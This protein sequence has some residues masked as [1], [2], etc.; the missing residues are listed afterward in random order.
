M[1]ASLINIIGSFGVSALLLSTPLPNF[2]GF[3][4]AHK[5]EVIAFYVLLF[6]AIVLFFYFFEQNLAPATKWLLIILFA[7]RNVAS[8]GEV[9]LIKKHKEVL[10]FVVNAGYALLFFASHYYFT[11][12]PFQMHLLLV[13]LITLTLLKAAVLLLWPV[14][15]PAEST[16]NKKGLISNWFFFGLNDLFG[17]TAKWIDKLFLVYL[18]TPAQFAVFFNGSIEIPLFALLI[19]VVGH[20]L[21]VE[22]APK[23][24]QKAEVVALFRSSF[25]LLA[26]VIFPLFFFFFCFS[27]DLF[28]ELFNNK[29][30]NAVSIFKVSVLIIPLRITN[31]TALLQCYGKGKTIIIGSVLDLA[32]SLLLMFLFFPH[33]GT[34]GIALAVVLGTYIQS[35]YYLW[36][37]AKVVGTSLLDLVPF[38]PLA[39]RFLINGI[40]FM[41]IEPLL[42]AYA[43]TTR[44]LVAFFVAALLVLLNLYFYLTVQKLPFQRLLFRNV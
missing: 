20:V 40:P 7:A 11:V 29:Y 34:I 24:H 43:G 12:V 2:I 42:H 18:L 37:S 4:K 15:Y 31:Y 1:Y 36:H 14:T 41:V 38:G 8:I 30:N 27:H 32:I 21:L 19:S 25:F 10:L 16:G 39:F 35:L 26:S 3:A 28:S 6:S 13:L 33:L 22:I 5:K 23:L 17:V 9:L 44:L